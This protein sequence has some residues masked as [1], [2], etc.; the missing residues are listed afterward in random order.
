[1]LNVV[2]LDVRVWLGQ[3]GILH[4]SLAL[5]WYGYV[6]HK[7]LFFNMGLLASTHPTAFISLGSVVF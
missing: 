1:M 6:D 5:V 7:G 2:L 3:R 4:Y